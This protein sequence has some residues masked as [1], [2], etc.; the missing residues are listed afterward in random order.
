MKCAMQQLHKTMRTE[1][2]CLRDNASATAP[3][4]REI[5]RVIQS[6]PFPSI[7][8]RSRQ[9]AIFYLYCRDKRRALK[10]IKL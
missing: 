3:L 2:Q 9:G 1:H 10:V 6:F 4:P 5:S 8:D 7:H